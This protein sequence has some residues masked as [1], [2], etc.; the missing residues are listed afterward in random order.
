MDTRAL[1]KAKDRLRLAKS[2]VE[3][4]RSCKT[5][6]EFFDQ[7]YVFLTSSKNIYTV[8]EQGSKSTPQSRQWFGKVKSLRKSDQLLQYLFEARNDEEHGLGESLRLQPARTTIGV[9]GAGASNDIMLNGGPFRNV[10]VTNFNK[11][12]QFEGG[13]P[14]GVTVHSLDSKPVKILRTPASTVL[15]E[16]NARGNRKYAPP[17]SHMTK[18]VLDKSPLGVATLAISYYEILLKEAEALRA[19]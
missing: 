9:A 4:L 11:A 7:W 13:V 16:V 8:L 1:E 3:N 2:A 18:E 14:E 10:R 12:V 5:Y 6:Q 15:V 17:T 19:D